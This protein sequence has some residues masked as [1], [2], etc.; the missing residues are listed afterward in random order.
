MT[1]QE[2][3]EI[4]IE[5]QTEFI[6]EMYSNDSTTIGEIKE[7]MNDMIEDVNSCKTPEDIVGFFVGRGWDENEAYMILFSYLIEG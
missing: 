3:K 7:A 6:N 4:I 5:D 1:L 2:L